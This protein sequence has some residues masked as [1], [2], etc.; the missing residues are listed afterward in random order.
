MRISRRQFVTASTA[1]P[2]AR[3]GHAGAQPA[4]PAANL[5]PAKEQVNAVVGFAP[6]GILDDAFD[7][8]W[9]DVERQFA[10]FGVNPL[11]DATAAR[12]ILIRSQFGNL[13]PLV[14]TA[15]RLEMELG[16]SELD[17]LQAVTVGIPPITVQ[18]AVLNRSTD[19]LS[20]VWEAAGYEPREGEHGTFWTIGEEGEVSLTHPVQKA[21]IA[22]LN[23]IAVL[24]ERILAFAPTAE[25][26]KQ[27]MATM[28]GNAAASTTGLAGLS[29]ALPD[30]AISVWYL[31][32]NFLGVDEFQVG[33][34]L[35]ESDTAAGAMPVIRRLCTGV[36]AGAIREGSDHDP[37]SRAFLI[38][39]TDEPDQAG[40]AAAVV[41]WRVTNMTS[42]VSGAPFS[43]LIGDFE[44]EVVSDSTLRITSAQA[45]SRATLFAMIGQRDIAPFAFV[46]GE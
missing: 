41:E 25:L 36:T 37:G 15:G 5:P 17:I 34:A 18:V 28:G 16:F 2:L 19:A 1:L 20:G 43:E 46:E 12:D 27:V 35:A 11:E 42:Q 14:Q 29:A 23:N 24:G 7:L 9:V 8:L 22:R 33:D 38:L 39:E 10:H 30:E 44:T 32:G 26:L 21:A 45:A 3:Y 13:P 4:T 40:Q 31:D 6:A